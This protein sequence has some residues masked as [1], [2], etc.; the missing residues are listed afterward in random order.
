M[1]FT[2][3]ASPQTG[4]PGAALLYLAIGVLVWPRAKAA[5]GGRVGRL[6]RA[7]QGVGRQGDLGHC[8]VEP[9]DPVA[10]P[11]QPSRRCHLGRRSANSVSGRARLA[12]RTSSCRWPTASGAAAA[13]SPWPAASSPS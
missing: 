2:G 1:L 11:G 5:D 12:V 13:R 4:A 3:M 8:V 6:R 9:G 10:A 7:P